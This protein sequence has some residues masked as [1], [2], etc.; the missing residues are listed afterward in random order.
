[1]NE[2]VYYLK[3]FVDG[4]QVYHSERFEEFK[5]DNISFETGFYRNK[6]Q[7]GEKKK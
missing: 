3:M 4:K 5:K 2:K 6:E 7:A 1:M